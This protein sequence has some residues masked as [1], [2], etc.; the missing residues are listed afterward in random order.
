MSKRIETIRQELKISKTEIAEK[1]NMDLA[2]YARLEKQGDRLK[3]FQICDIALAL[4][5]SVEYLLFGDKFNN[6]ERKKN[7][8]DKHIKL[9]NDKIASLEKDRY[10]YRSLVTDFLI[11]ELKNN[12]INEAE[13]SKIYHTINDI[14]IFPTETWLRREA[15]KK[16]KSELDKEIDLSFSEYDEID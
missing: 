13:L 15:E 8:Y 3:Y 1:L 5:V 14:F 12:K 2:N 6:L 16:G 10:V 11:E 4:G 9:L 7:A